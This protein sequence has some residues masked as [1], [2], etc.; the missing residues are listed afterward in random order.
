MALSYKYNPDHEDAFG[1]QIEEMLDCHNT[2]YYEIWIGTDGY[3]V[4]S[5]EYKVYDS[6]DGNEELLFQ[7]I[8][9]GLE[10]LLRLITMRAGTAY[11]LTPEGYEEKTGSTDYPYEL[12]EE[13]GLT[14]VVVMVLSLE[15]VL[16]RIRLEKYL[17]SNI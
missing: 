2:D 10:E 11:A 13:L 17:N 1:K 16:E 6:Y 8:G 7:E 4:S 12:A 9:I 3:A 5:P 15:D 14:S